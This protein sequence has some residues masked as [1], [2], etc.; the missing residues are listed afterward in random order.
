LIRRGIIDAVQNAEGGDIMLE[1][2]EINTPRYDS[3]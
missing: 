2:R 1:T 3:N